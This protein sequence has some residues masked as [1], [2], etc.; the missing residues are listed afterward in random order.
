MSYAQLVHAGDMESA[1]IG[2][3][4]QSASESVTE[5][6][7]LSLFFTLEL[8]SLEDAELAP[9]LADPVMAHYRSWV[10]EIPSAQAP[11]ALRRSGDAAA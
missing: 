9:K 5:I 2:Q 4:Y 10:E 11:S 1:S 7:A 3:F 6:S 8:N